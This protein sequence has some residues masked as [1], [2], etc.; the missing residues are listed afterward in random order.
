MLIWFTF[1]GLAVFV[2]AIDD[3]HNSIV[4]HRGRTILALRH[5]VARLPMVIVTAA[6]AWPLFVFVLGKRVVNR[7]EGSNNQVDGAK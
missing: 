6:V 1:G 2:W 5:C 4:R 3:L 7:K